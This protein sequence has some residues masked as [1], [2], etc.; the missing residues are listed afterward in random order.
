MKEPTIDR[1]EQILSDELPDVP[2]F[3]AATSKAGHRK[4]KATGGLNRWPKS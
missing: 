2:Y 1:D 3:P 4:K